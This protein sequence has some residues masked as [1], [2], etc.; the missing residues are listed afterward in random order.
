[1]NYL[2]MKQRKTLK[3]R[4]FL[5]FPVRPP[6][7]VPFMLIISLQSDMEDNTIRVINLTTVSL[8]LH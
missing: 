4:L 2:A 1:M 3:P 7:N 5:S 6:K 8:S